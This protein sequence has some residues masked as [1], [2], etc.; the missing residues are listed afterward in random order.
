MT[1]SVPLNSWPMY[2]FT[3]FGGGAVGIGPLRLGFE[4]SPL[5][6]AKY[7][8]LSSGLKRTDVGYQPVGMKP[9]DLAL[10]RSETLN[11]DRLLA[12][13]LATNNIWP[14]GVRARLFGVLPLGADG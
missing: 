9:S 14:S 11:T 10:A 7:T 1:P 6:L 5:P 12:S 8:F 2:S 3:L 4:T 13:A